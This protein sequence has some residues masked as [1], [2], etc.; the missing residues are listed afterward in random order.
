MDEVDADTLLQFAAARVQHNRSLPY[1][2]YLLNSLRPVFT[3]KVERMAVDGYLRLYINPD[4]IKSLE[5]PVA[6]WCL[7]HERDHIWRDHMGRY[8]KL[9]GA[10]SAELAQKWNLYAADPEINDDQIAIAHQ[11]QGRN[12]LVPWGEAVTPA[13]WGFPD[14]LSAEEYFFMAADQQKKQPQAAPAQDGQVA[15]GDAGEQQPIAGEGEGQEASG[16]Q[17]GSGSGGPM[18][19][20]ELP[21]DDIKHPG[22][23]D[24]EK[25]SVL[26]AVARDIIEHH[27]LYAGKAGD[28]PFGDLIIAEGMLKSNVNYKEHLLAT[29]QEGVK[30]MRHGEAAKTYSK[31]PKSFMLHDRILMPARVE[32]NPPMAFVMDMSGSMMGDQK[33]KIKIVVG[34]IDTIVKRFHLRRVPVLAC[35]AV[36]HA[37][38]EI[39]DVSSLEL[40]GG[41]GTNM[42]E[43]INRA[44]ELYPTPK[45]IIVITDGETPWPTQPLPETRLMA[46]V[47]GDEPEFQRVPAFISKVRIDPN[48]VM[49]I[50]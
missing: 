11:T 2:R 24:A 23:T 37:V 4:F 48:D 21:P 43:G 27:K 44:A 3:D 33:K 39:S 36:V 38:S 14:N 40:R 34:E 28:V 46:V 15:P 35:D 12:K 32:T 49:S 8:Q 41:G 26:R 42:V 5:V 22:A 45:L 19:E 17:C 13:T 16:W 31:R 29:L 20:W 30:T 1:F 9:F 47:I 6:A 25:K 10:G 7:A 50:D 18:R